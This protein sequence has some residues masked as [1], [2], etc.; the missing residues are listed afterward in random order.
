[1]ASSI[2]T[3]PQRKLSAIAD[4][5]TCSMVFAALLRAQTCVAMTTFGAESN[6]SEAAASSGIRTPF[7]K[8]VIWIRTDEA[9]VDALHIGAK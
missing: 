2:R 7:T 4:R 9:T 3:L 8:T 1:M 6:T 5:G